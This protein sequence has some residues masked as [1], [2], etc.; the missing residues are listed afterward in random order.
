MR[1]EPLA[2]DR[3][4]LSYTG[5]KLPLKLTSQLQCSEIENRNTYFGANFDTQDRLVLVHKVVYSSVDMEH[6]YSYHQNG[7]LSQAEILDA[8]DSEEEVRILRFDESGKPI[9][10]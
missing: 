4:F 10:D 7:I 9:V 2:Y 1:K 8:N 6:K 5:I 3:Y